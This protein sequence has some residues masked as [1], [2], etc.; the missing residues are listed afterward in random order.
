[1]SLPTAKD[2][3]DY[4]EGYC[5]DNTI[6]SQD[7][8]NKRITRQIL[9]Y[10]ERIT[11]LSFQ[12]PKTITEYQS[13]NG[14]NLIYLDRRPVNSI[15]QITFTNVINDTSNFVDSIELVSG[16][17]IIVATGR[18]T[19]GIPRSVWPKGDYNI[20]ITY[21]YGFT[22]FTDPET[23]NLVD[24]EEA[25]ICLAA[26]MVLTQV[27]ARTGGGNI[28]GQQWSR[29]HGKRGKYTETLNLC[30]QTAHALLRKYMSSVV[31]Y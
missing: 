1:M 28:G 25:I 26:K 11:R 23:G 9:P 19:E 22:D 8:I 5:I 21:T 30:D 20:K 12:A 29:S 14:T 13:G 18:P 7:W 2:V 10:I 4:L 16:E 17:G 15:S 24:I 31:G 27:G 3:Y 6:I